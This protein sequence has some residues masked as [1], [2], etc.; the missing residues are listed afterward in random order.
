MI[1]IA[2]VVA[3]ERLTHTATDGF[4]ITSITSTLPYNPIWDIPIL[5]E[6]LQILDQAFN[7]NYFYIASGSQSFV[8][9]SEDQRYVIK[10][11]KHKRWRLSPLLS[12]I[13]LPPFLNK[14]RGKWINKKKRTIN[15]TFN[16]CKTSYLEFHDQTGIIYLHLNKTD[17]LHR[18]IIISDRLGIKHKLDLDNI[19]FILQKKA[20]R[21]DYYL[22]NLRKEGKIDEAKRAIDSL[23]QFAVTR[24]QKGFSDKDPHFVYNFGFIGSEVIE[25]DIGGF[26]RDPRKP[27]SYFYSYEI[28]KIRNKLLPWIKKNYPELA[29][30]TEKRIDEIITSQTKL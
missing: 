26:Y 18:K 29:P 9:E 16:S 8:F 20:I 22:K 19:E 17:H 14:K 23:L 5:E 27:T 11:F 4:G 24:A 7:Q 13:P 6:D 3:V 28:V 2:G 25:I 15:S 21:T 12:K 30:F 1:I 10:F